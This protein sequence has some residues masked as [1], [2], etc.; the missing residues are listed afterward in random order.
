MLPPQ[1]GVFQSPEHAL[2][3]QL[4]AKFEGDEPH[5]LPRQWLAWL[6]IAQPLWLVVP[7]LAW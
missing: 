1:F 7:C 2:P 3:A 5:V 6:V 4:H